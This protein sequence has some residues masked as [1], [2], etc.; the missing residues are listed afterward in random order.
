MDDAS[1]CKIVELSVTKKGAILVTDK[2]TKRLK[3]FSS[4]H[5]LLSYLDIPNGPLGV[6]A[7]DD[8]DFPKA[9]VSAKDKCI[10]V[11][12]ISDFRTMVIIN[13]I[14]LDYVILSIATCLNKMV[15]IAIS[16]PR[17]VK[18]L[19][20]DGTV[21]WTLKEDKKDKPLFGKAVR[22][23]SFGSEN[24]K[25]VVSDY[26][27]KTLSFIDCKDGT[28]IRRLNLTDVG[29]MGLTF[30]PRQANL[31]LIAYASSEGSGE[32]AHPRSL[33]RTSAARSYKH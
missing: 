1:V 5:I 19:E 33:A 3:L 23:A 11:I 2:A 20:W 4:N 7:I 15:V 21:I 24:Q 18:M 22:I 32:P 6:V 25:V 26:K 13:T 27:C 17:S 31:V 8:I 10:H 14:Q 29:P 9:V 30:G 28:I 12:D 16:K